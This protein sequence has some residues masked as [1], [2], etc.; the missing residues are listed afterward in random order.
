MRL[1]RSFEFT[2]RALPHTAYFSFIGK[3]KSEDWYMIA[4]ECGPLST[5]AV[6]GR[7]RGL[8]KDA[9]SVQATHQSGWLLSSDY[10]ESRPALSARPAATTS[11]M[12]KFAVRS[13]TTG[14]GVDEAVRLSRSEFGIEPG[15]D[16]G[17]RELTVARNS[18]CNESRRTPLS[19]D[20]Q[21]LT[22]RFSEARQPRLNRL[23][24]SQAVDR[25]QAQAIRR[26]LIDTFGK[27]TIDE[28]VQRDNTPVLHL[29]WRKPVAMNRR[30]RTVERHELVARIRVSN[31]VTFIC[32]NLIEPGLE[33]A[34]SSDEPA[35][36]ARF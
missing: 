35:H 19:P 29:A 17:E 6:S 8:T 20:A 10:A 2:V 22:A 18:D 13:L 34:D 30:G 28:T 11:P 25:D 24:Y 21:C 26:Q 31:N 3:M 16:A 15:Y 9:Y 33:I 5:I 7:L 36:Q 14:M 12:S 4:K 23:F 1:T 32:L 27:P